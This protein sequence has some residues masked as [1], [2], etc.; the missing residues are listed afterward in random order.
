VGKAATERPRMESKRM[1]N[2]RGGFRRQLVTCLGNR[3]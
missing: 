3:E 1:V 2:N